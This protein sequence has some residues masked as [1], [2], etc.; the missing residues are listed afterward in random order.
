MRALFFLPSNSVGAGNENL[1]ICGVCIIDPDLG[2]GGLGGSLSGPLS[3][4]GLDLG[5]SVWGFGGFCG[6][7][8]EVG[9]F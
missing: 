8:G 1:A 4:L 3:D 2:S 9:V 7:R 5:G 6:E